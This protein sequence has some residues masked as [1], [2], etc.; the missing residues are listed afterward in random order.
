LKASA[1][2]RKGNEIKR[3]FR[4]ILA[5]KNIAK[6]LKVHL[7]KQETDVAATPTSSSDESL[8]GTPNDVQSI[9]VSFDC[10]SGDQDQSKF[11]EELKNAIKE[12]EE[13]QQQAVND[14]NADE[15]HEGDDEQDAVED[16]CLNTHMGE[17]IFMVIK[18]FLVIADINQMKRKVVAERNFILSIVYPEK[19]I[20]KSRS[21][22]R[23]E[24][25]KEAQ[26]TEAT[27][28][29]LGKFITQNRVKRMAEFKD[30]IEN[31]QKEFY[32]NQ[33]TLNAE[34][35]HVSQTLLNAN[36]FCA[37]EDEIDTMKQRR[38][39]LMVELRE[40]KIKFDN[41]TAKIKTDLMNLQ[42]LLS[43]EEDPAFLPEKKKKRL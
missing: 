19:V 2:I 21:V 16:D 3:Q 20:T 31:K 37:D 33:Q 18:Y 28:G 4:K 27:T 14:H 43:E 38:R 25:K 5:G 24:M 40:L 41:D 42:N 9:E 12:G 22:L 29:V 30:E 26:N 10:T 1:L 32:I 11:Y 35:F 6:L 7:K 13:Q 15:D 17:L 8:Q 36:V 34:V 23:K 39:E